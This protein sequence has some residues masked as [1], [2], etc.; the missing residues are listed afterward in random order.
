VSPE[1]LFEIVKLGLMGIGAGISGAIATCGVVYL[2]RG[3]FE[4]EAL[5]A[6]ADAAKA[7]AETDAITAR[8]IRELTEDISHLQ[9]Q[10]AAQPVLEPKVA[11][12]EKQAAI[13]EA[14]MT[15]MAEDIEALHER[16]R[17]CEEWRAGGVK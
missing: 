11:M 16:L 14:A 8:L 5:K 13:R 3:K 12:L 4:A 1:Q 15:I 2:N 10:M 17:Q 9:R 7:D 6:R